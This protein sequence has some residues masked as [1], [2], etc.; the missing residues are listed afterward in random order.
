[1]NLNPRAPGWLTER[2][3][4]VEIIPCSNGRR[5]WRENQMF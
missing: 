5:G 1:L 3:V 2:Y 4:V